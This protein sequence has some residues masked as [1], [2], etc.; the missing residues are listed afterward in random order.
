MKHT[1]K[2]IT[3]L[4]LLWAGAAQAGLMYTDD[5]ANDLPS[6][7]GHFS[8]DLDALSAT[9]V[10]NFNNS[11]DVPRELTADGHT[12][13]FRNSS[14]SAPYIYEA[15][16]YSWMDK[17]FIG[18]STNKIVIYLDKAVQAVKFNVGVTDAWGSA[19]VWFGAWIDGTKHTNS[20][21]PYR[22]AGGTQHQYGMYLSDAG[23]SCKGFN[24][25]II[26]P[27]P[28]NWGINMLN[29]YYNDSPK[30]SDVPEPGALSLLGAGLL[31]LGWL[32]H[33]RRRRA[34]AA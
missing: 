29:F 1:T 5:P 15:D 14:T 24:K 21:S 18:T 20:S 10:S 8:L 2:L 23:D 3:A 17:R 28:A 4:A 26:D 33:R 22:H 31:G 6:L 30:C 13:K 27:P 32:Q 12:Y 25:I 11:T 7:G 19:N 16:D 34:P 9:T